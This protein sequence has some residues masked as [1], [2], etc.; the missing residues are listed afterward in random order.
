MQWETETKWYPSAKACEQPLVIKST[1]AMQLL[2]RGDESLHRWCIHEVKR[3]QVVDAHC[4]QR[5]NGAR[6]VRSLDLR[7]IWCHHLIAVRSFRVQPVTFAGTRATSSA[8]SLF[9][10]SLVNNTAPMAIRYFTALQNST[11]DDIISHCSLNL[12]LAATYYT[13]KN[14]E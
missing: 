8:W 2:H 9:C 7:H 6:K 5:Q 4:L 12:F 3:Q 1:Q 13:T 14:R 10:L 11:F